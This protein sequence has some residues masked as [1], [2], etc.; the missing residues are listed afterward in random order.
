[1]PSEEGPDGL[2]WPE[3]SGLFYG[4]EHLNLTPWLM[5]WVRVRLAEHHSKIYETVPKGAI[6]IIV[7]LVLAGMAA[8]EEDPPP[9]EE[10]QSA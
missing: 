6:P 9:E 10:Q 2:G 3:E 5:E 8:A 7:H 1:M 4:N